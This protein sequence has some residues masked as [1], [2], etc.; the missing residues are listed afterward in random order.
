MTLESS[1]RNKSIV[2][3]WFIFYN[4]IVIMALVSHAKRDCIEQ[5]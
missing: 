4:N 5:V 3:F 2:W 1:R